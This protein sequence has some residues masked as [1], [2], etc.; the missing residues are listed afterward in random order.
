MQPFNF[1]LKSPFTGLVALDVFE[2]FTNSSG[3][4]VQEESPSKEACENSAT[5]VSLLSQSTCTTDS[6]GSAS[7]DSHVQQHQKLCKVSTG[8]NIQ[9]SEILT[10]KDDKNSLGP[11]KT[12]KPSLVSAMEKLVESAHFGKLGN[13]LAPVYLCLGFMSGG[14]F[15]LI[16]GTGYTRTLHPQYVIKG[17]EYSGLQKTKNIDC[18]PI[19]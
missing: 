13:N 2:E 15:I 5:T 4:H 9:N 16:G 1:F 17:G 6:S 7:T 19:R 11:A 14:Y 18:E 10:W 3:I 12:E 8:V